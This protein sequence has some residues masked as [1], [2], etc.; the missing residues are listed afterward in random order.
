LFQKCFCEFFHYSN[1]SSL[2]C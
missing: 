2:S 1:Y